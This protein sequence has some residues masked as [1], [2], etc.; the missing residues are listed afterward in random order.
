MVRFKR[1]QTF[2]FVGQL[3]NKGLPYP[4][5]GCTLY[6][7][8]RS[9]PNFEFIQHM[10]CSVVDPVTSL[11]RIYAVNTD[12]AK[13]LAMPHVIDVRLVNAAGKVLISNT[14]EIDVLDTV[15]EAN[16]A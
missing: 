14:V 6:A 3:T 9:V 8:I 10:T 7:D 1:G 4:L 12:T 15:T 2:D 5:A 16:T 11:V 13:W